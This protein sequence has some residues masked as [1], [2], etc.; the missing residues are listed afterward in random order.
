MESWLLRRAVFL[1]FIALV[2]FSCAIRYPLVVGRTADI[3]SWSGFFMFA[4]SLAFAFYVHSLFPRSHKRPGDFKNLLTD[5]PY[6]YVRHPFYAAFIVMGFGIALWCISVPGLIAYAIMLPLWEK[7]AEIEERELLEYW[8][9]LYH[10]FM[11]TRGRFFPR[12]ASR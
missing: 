4:V 9:D 11:R 2:P 5:G 8:G 7:V 3:I 10:E 6:R 1:L 12:R